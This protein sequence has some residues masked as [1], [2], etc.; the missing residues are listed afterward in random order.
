MPG[1]EYAQHVFAMAVSGGV[2]FLLA[3]RVQFVADLSRRAASEQAIERTRQIAG[4]E[5][6]L[7]FGAESVLL[8]ES[9][10]C[11]C[12]AG[13]TPRHTWQAALESGARHIAADMLRY[14]L[15]AARLDRVALRKYSLG[16]FRSCLVLRLSSDVDSMA[17][18]VYARDTLMPG[19]R[20]AE[21]IRRLVSPGPNVK[22]NTG[23]TDEAG[24]RRSLDLARQEMSLLR[25]QFLR[26][27]HDIRMPL[28]TILLAADR[29]VRE[30]SK[31]QDAGAGI[32]AAMGEIGER[33]A[34][35]GQQL[36][37]YL[38]SLL[39]IESGR[40][41][42]GDSTRLSPGSVLL[43]LIDARQP[44]FEKRGVR[45]RMGEIDPQWTAKLPHATLMRALDNLIANALRFTPTGGIVTVGSHQ[46]NDTGCVWIEDSGPGLSPADFEEYVEM[47]RRNL[48]RSGG[49]HGIGLAAAF[50]M[51]RVMG[52]RLALERPLLGS[53][54][55]F[56]LVLPAES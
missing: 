15:H 13:K 23:V 16:L 56:L 54:A 7:A 55:R 53:G 24:L 43:A 21:Q 20:H 12:A 42:E 33:L 52:G 14:D 31:P 47:G 1:L 44:E 4:M 40:F 2:I 28:G 45:L 39:A 9:G 27:A 10:Q 8:V 3:A 5:G 22:E 25:M 19:L 51:A 34:R 11:T 36:R 17:F 41:H 49:G 32:P 26:L 38:D 30:L 37:L 46:S 18:L 29:L 50:E 35:Q 6:V 48:G